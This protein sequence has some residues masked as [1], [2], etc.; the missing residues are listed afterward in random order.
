MTSF[1]IIIVEKLGSLKLLQIKDFKEEE[2]YKKCGLKKSEEFMNQVEWNVKLNGINYIVNVYAKT[3]GRAN[4]ENKYDFPPP[5]DKLLFYGNCAIVAKKKNN[6]G[7]IEVTNL[8]L[9]TWNLIYEKLFGG[10]ENLADT[11]D[12]DE[13]DEDELDKI[14]PQKKTKNVI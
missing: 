10:F 4:N 2:L 6:V 1:T 3:E 11:L 12:V 7:E 13:D 9:E 8:S 14:P 5:I